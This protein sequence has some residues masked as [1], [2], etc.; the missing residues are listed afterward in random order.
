[1]TNCLR[2]FCL[3]CF[4]VFIFFI[5]GYGQK[6]MAGIYENH[7]NNL[8]L[9]CDSSF[10]G[11]YI[12]SKDTI[13]GAGRWTIQKNKLILH[14]DSVWS[15]DYKARNIVSDLIIKD[16]ILCY[17]KLARSVYHKIKRA[18]KE[19]YHPRK[20]KPFSEYKKLYDVKFKRTVIFDC[21]RAR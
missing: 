10:H 11:N 20:V 3:I 2:P 18:G 14:T 16:S 9:E 12:R 21:T 13:T 7:L 4:V 19:E 5:Q 15:K 17:P 6:S 8:I 1:M